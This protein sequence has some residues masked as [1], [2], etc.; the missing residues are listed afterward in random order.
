MKDEDLRVEILAHYLLNEMHL[1]R[2]VLSDLLEGVGQKQNAEAALS[3]DLK[4]LEAT[5]DNVF[6]L[7]SRLISKTS[8][9]DRS[10]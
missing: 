4:E 5:L 2:S 7:T 9:I 8:K 1:A 6:Q 3:A 10:K